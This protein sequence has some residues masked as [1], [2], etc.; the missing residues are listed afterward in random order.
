MPGRAF[1]DT[2]ILV[3]AF[4]RSEP[5]KQARAA[6]LVNDLMDADL[7]VLS[8][9]VLKEFFVV[10]TRKI[11]TPLA[12][13]DAREIIDDLSVMFVVDDTLPLLRKAL[14]IHD[15]HGLSLWDATVIAAA[16]A[17]GCARLYSED[18][19]HGQEIHGVV[20]TNPFREGSHEA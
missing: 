20:I 12:Y 11:A 5:A 13:H 18:M 19:S 1:L 10:A 16:S 7:A 8:V 3:Y 9:Q 4:D 6:A 15:A 2:N 14:A 17:A